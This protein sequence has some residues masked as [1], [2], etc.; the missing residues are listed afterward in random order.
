MIKVLASGGRRRPLYNPLLTL[1]ATHEWP[2]APY[3]KALFYLSLNMVADVGRI[4]F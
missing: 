1:L 4:L 2:T 3:Q